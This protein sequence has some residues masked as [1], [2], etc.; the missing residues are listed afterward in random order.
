[1]HYNEILR[2]VY[3]QQIKWLNRFVR[4]KCIKNVCEPLAFWF[5]PTVK[6]KIVEIIEKAKD[7]ID[8]DCFSYL[9][10][11]E[12]QQIY[13]LSRRPLKDKKCWWW[14]SFRVL[15]ETELLEFEKMKR[16]LLVE[17]ELQLISERHG[18]LCPDLAVGFRIGKIARRILPKEGGVIEAG[19][20]SC[21][22]DALSQMGNWNIRVNP[23][24]GKHLYNLKKGEQLLLSIEL[25]DSFL[26][27]TPEL[28]SLEDKLFQQKATIEEAARYQ[29]EIDRQVESILQVKDHE[30]FKGI[31]CPDKE[32]TITASG[33]C[34]RC[35]APL[36]N[37]SPN[38]FFCQKCRDL[39]S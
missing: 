13:C 20:I 18:H 10:I 34:L 4:V 29:I 15:N 6:L 9:V 30:L 25:N 19:C 35:G 22:L 36:K 31:P 28:C 1:M 7:S 17:L 39:L 8:L 5:S 2:A 37:N 33:F 27:Y 24:I 14:V 16:M 23:I 21:A 3:H 32:K 11:T 12:D 38:K 26:S